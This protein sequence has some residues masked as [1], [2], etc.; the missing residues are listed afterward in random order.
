MWDVLVMSDVASFSFSASY[1]RP[2]AFSRG[3]ELPEPCPVGVGKSA[4]VIVCRVAASATFE[5]LGAVV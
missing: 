1:F 3:G 4:L 5:T 2:M